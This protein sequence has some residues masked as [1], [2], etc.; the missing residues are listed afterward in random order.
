M[1]FYRL[2]SR[3]MLAI[4]F[5]LAGLNH[6]RSPDFYLRIM[7]SYVPWHQALVTISGVFEIAG[8]LL[9][10][11]KKTRRL[12][13]YGLIALLIAVLPANVEAALRYGG[14]SAAAWKRI[15]LW[16]RIPFQG[17]FAAWVWWTCLTVSHKT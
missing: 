10:L 15:L 12:A 7:P 14:P 1:S 2:I 9:I 5:V 11:P 17:V 13:G 4:A 8:G 6:F 16:L 3:W